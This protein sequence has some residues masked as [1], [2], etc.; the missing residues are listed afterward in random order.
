MSHI[1]KSNNLNNKRTDTKIYWA[2]LNNFLSN[3]KIPSLLP[4]LISG[5]TI[6]NIVEKANIFN[7]CFASQCTP[8][9][10]SVKVP[11][12]LMNTDKLQ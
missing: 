6:T 11:L 2:I 4:I 7:G 5:E 8:L 9:K 3:I 10:N 1:R 12:L